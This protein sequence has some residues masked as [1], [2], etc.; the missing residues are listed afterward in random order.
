MSLAGAYEKEAVALG[1]HGYSTQAQAMAN[2]NSV[3]DWNLPV[4]AGLN[5]LETAYKQEGGASGLAGANSP[6]NLGAITSDAGNVADFLTRLTSPHTWLR[7]GEFTAGLLLL[8]VGLKAVITPGNAPVARQTV[9]RTA[10]TVAKRVA[11]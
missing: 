9:S 7:V 5:A 8:Y 11:K 10:K 6:V 2:P 4:V 1:F 3:P